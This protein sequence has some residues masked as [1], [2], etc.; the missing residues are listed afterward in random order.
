MDKACRTPSDVK[1]NGDF[2]SIMT[3]DDRIRLLVLVVLEICH[4]V[5]E[6]RVNTTTLHSFC[7]NRKVTEKDPQPLSGRRRRSG[8]LVAGKPAIYVVANLRSV[9]CIG[10]VCVLS[11]RTLESDRLSLDF[12]QLCF[13]WRPNHPL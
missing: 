8:F 6:I 7:G 2:S 12:L 13:R 4:G 11:F 5:K 3:R 10:A 1:G 9:P